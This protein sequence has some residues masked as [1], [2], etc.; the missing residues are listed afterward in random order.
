MFAPMFGI[1]SF[2]PAAIPTM[3]GTAFGFSILSSTTSTFAGATTSAN[4]KVGGLTAPAVLL[5]TEQH[6]GD[7]IAT[8]A[9]LDVTAAYNY[10]KALTPVGR[11]YLGAAT[12]PV[13][14]SPTFAGDMAL[15]RFTPGVY[16]AGAAITNSTNVTF[17]AEGDANAQFVIQIGAAFAPAAA[18]Q[19]LLVNGAKASNIFWAVTGAVAMAASAKFKGTILSLGAIGCAAGASVEGRLL[20]TGAGTITLSENVITTT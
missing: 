6:Y 14:G 16:F 3:L 5:G 13:A 17:D 2:A 12:T 19:V 7:A 15:L 18:S 11:I 10:Y 1:K 8:Q 4:K 9:L 20:T